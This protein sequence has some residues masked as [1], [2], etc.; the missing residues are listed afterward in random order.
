MVSLF[1][2]WAAGVTSMRGC[3]EEAERN[4]INS[5]VDRA[6]YGLLFWQMKIAPIEVMCCDVLIYVH[7]VK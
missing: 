1:Y 3:R 4:Q 5:E 6:P 2:L 7:I